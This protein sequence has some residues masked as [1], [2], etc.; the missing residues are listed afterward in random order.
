MGMVERDECEG[1][2]TQVDVWACGVILYTLLVGFP[3][4]WHRKQLMMIRLIMEGRFSFSSPDWRDITDPPK[5]LIN[6]LLVVDPNKRIT[7]KQ[8]LQHVFLQV[9]GGVEEITKVPFDA[10]KCFKL[11]I[12]RVRFLVRLK[13]LKTTPEPLSLERASVN[14]YS[15]RM[16][17]RTIDGAAF[18]VYSHWVKRGEGQNRAAM[19]EHLPKTELKKAG[20]S[21]DLVLGTRETRNLQKSFRVGCRTSVDHGMQY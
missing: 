1:Y 4:F 3:P 2:N 14:P 12:I 9:P 19:F 20:K 13:R 17:R 18:Q 8:A 7:V 11:T 16:F 21:T 15:M 6:L 10:R 5:D